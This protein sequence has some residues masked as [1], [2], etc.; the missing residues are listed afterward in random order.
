MA[1]R[2]IFARTIS[3]SMRRLKPLIRTISLLF[4]SLGIA[5]LCSRCQQ[6][7]QLTRDELRALDSIYLVRRNDLSVI[8]NDSC[9]AYRAVVM[10]QLVDSI[11]QQRL[12]EIRN[13][14][15]GHEAQ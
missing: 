8:V 11:M 12:L 13:L 6:E 4:C 9:V 1:I 3:C 2:I 7:V 10:N 14:L 15:Q 5:L